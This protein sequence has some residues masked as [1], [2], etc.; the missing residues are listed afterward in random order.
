MQ[1]VSRLAKAIF[2]AQTRDMIR[3]LI[4]C[5]PGLDDA[6]ALLA[7]FGAPELDVMAITTV[8][9]NVNATLTAKNARIIR[10]A[11]GIGA[12]VPVCAGAPRPLC[13]VQVTAEDFH[14]TDGLGDRGFPVPKIDLSRT[15]S[16]NMIID[17]CRAAMGDPITVVVT[18]PMTNLALALT[19]APDI[20]AGIQEV[21][22]MGGADTEGGN[23]TPFAEF[24]I[25]ADPHAASIVFNSGLPVRCACLDVTHKV[26]ATKKRVEKVRRAGS[27]QAKLAADLLRASC[28]YEFAANGDKDVPLHDPSTIVALTR[29]DLFRGRRASVEVVTEPGEQF[30][31]TIPSF[32]ETGN[33]TWYETADADAVFDE[34]ARLMGGYG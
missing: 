33:V 3:I 14:G 17:T 5:D 25:Y 2:N 7:A 10:E 29:P 8:A 12:D 11:A 31:R 16:V 26:R 28:D 21:V 27:A 24:N 4:D 19:M 30:G 32:T 18:G 23:I 6:V 9:G 20:E 15:H 34:L 22:I 13:R 1:R